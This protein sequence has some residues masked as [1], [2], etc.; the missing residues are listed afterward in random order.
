MFDRDDGGEIDGEEL[1]N[2]LFK[3]QNISEGVMNKIKQSK[4]DEPRPEL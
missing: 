1:R 4:E 2:E 3:G